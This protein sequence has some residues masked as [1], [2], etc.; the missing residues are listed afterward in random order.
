M[1]ISDWSSDVCSSDLEG[2][3]V[4]LL[5]DLDLEHH[6]ALVAKAHLAADQVGL[7]HAAEALVVERGD[8]LA[9]GL[10]ASLPVAQRLRIVQPQHLD[11]GHHPHGVLDHRQHLAIG[12]ASCREL[13]CKYV[14]IA[15]V[16]VSLNKTSA[17]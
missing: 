2:H 3:G 1:R 17:I 11:V 6:E 15:V 7:P 14:S 13:G 9:V 8:L 4:D 5:G 10:E 16:A 12:R